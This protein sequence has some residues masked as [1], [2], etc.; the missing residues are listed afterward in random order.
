MIDLSTETYQW[1]KVLHIISIICWMAGLLYLPR[2]FVYHTQVD[3]ASETSALFKVMERRLYYGIM[4]PAMISSWGFGLVLVLFFGFASGGWLHAK[5]TLAV[6]MTVGHFMLGYWRSRFAE[7]K[8]TH[9][10]RFYRFFNEVPTVFM[11]VMVIVVVIKP[12]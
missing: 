3:P 10:T 8:N 2:L 6:L 11:I 7:D 1:I 12:F 5:L 4:I 9:S